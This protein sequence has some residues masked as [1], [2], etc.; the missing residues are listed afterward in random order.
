MGSY[1]SCN[2][3]NLS[4]QTFKN[5]IDLGILSLFRPDDKLVIES[6]KQIDSLNSVYPEFYKEWF[7]DNEELKVVLYEAPL[8]IIRDR[9]NILGY[10][11][12]NA[13]DA[14]NSWVKEERNQ[15][16]KNY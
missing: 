7:E 13:Q 14:F 6:I 9:L 16:L 2:L 8:S 1:A 11:L 4:I 3:G 5:D 12:K 10:N 15:N